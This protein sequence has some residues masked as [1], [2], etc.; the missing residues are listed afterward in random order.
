VEQKT[1]R[2]V[3]N[4]SQQREE[5]REG[6]TPPIILDNAARYPQ[7]TAPTEIRAVIVGRNE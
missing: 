5:A 2:A 6:E 4:E 7:S 1:E 3:T